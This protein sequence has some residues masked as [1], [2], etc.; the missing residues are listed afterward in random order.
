MKDKKVRIATKKETEGLLELIRANVEAMSHMDACF[1]WRQTPGVVTVRD[2]SKVDNEVYHHFFLPDNLRGNFE[3]PGC[4]VETLWKLLQA[5]KL[6]KEAQ[7]LLMDLM[8]KQEQYLAIQVE[9]YAQMTL[10]ELEKFVSVNDTDDVASIC[11]ALRKAS[12]G[13]VLFNAMSGNFIAQSLLRHLS[14]DDFPNDD[15]ASLIFTI[16]LSK[17]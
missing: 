15:G 7:D 11:L 6:D 12:Y 14:A 9:K 8:E 10:D 5:G 2:V 17:K 13:D 16:N 4:D 3:D 1:F